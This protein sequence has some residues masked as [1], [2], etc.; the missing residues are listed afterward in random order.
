MILQRLGFYTLSGIISALIG[1]SLCQIFLIDMGT[2]VNK[3]PLL[4]DFFDKFPPDIILLPVV[5]ACLSV[6]MVVVEIFLNNPTRYKANKRILP[7]YLWTAIA[8]GIVAGLVSAAFTWMLYASALPSGVVR[9]VSW[10]LIGLF[11]GLGESISWQFRSIEGETSKAKKRILRVTLFGFFAGFIASIIVEIIHSL[12]NLEGIQDAVG[13]LI[14]GIS[15]GAFLSFGTSPSYQAALRAGYGFE[16]YIDK[17]GDFPQL[18]N[19]LLRFVS[20][21]IDEEEKY[22]E[23][24]LSIQL[25]SKLEKPLFIGSD[26]GADIY[27][28]NLPEKC[29]SIKIKERNYI[30]KCLTEDSVK[31][32]QDLKCRGE[33]ATLR[34]NQILTLYC[35]NANNKNA[36]NFYR[37]VFYDRFLDPQA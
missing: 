9:V 12:I 11:T 10:S 7:P 32:N 13:F 31:I 20:E 25:P 3:L 26:T 36:K 1:W 24:G 34:H 19:S 37:F 30:I 21:D 28:P 14:L 29:A 23:E 35:K 22:I 27:I 18:K 4:K 8:A 15:L 2:I 33:E 5:A 16:I 17:S 6:A